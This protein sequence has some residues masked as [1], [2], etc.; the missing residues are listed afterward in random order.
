M[1]LFSINQPRARNMTG[2]RIIHALLHGLI[3]YLFPYTKHI[4][5]RDKLV[6][7][8]T[9]WRVLRLR[10]E[11]RPADRKGSCKYIEQQSRTADKE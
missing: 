9:A 7:V 1:S 8:T 5:F 10:M 3:H 2:C 6:P 4:N 11:Q